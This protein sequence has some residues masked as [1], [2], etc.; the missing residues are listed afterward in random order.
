MKE[1]AEKFYKGR[2]WRRCRAGF[3]K[4]RQGIDGGLCQECGEKLGFIVHHI[5]ELTP[6]NI[7]NPEISLSWSNLKYVCKG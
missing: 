3:I 4:H 1:W 2:L 5:T 6:T 7:N